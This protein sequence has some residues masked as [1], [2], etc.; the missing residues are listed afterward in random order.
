MNEAVAQ[1]I[2]CQSQY[3]LIRSGVPIKE[4]TERAKITD[5]KNLLGTLGIGLADSIVTTI[6]AFKPQKNL[7]DFLKI[8]LILKNRPNLKFLV[9]GDGAL[10]Q[11]LE[12][13]ILDLG[14]GGNTLLWA[15][16]K[17]SPRY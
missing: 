13:Q 10:R 4:I 15:G 11:N 7:T 2:G 16:G 3:K 14:I 5:K 6:G 17:I 12:K 8:S 1:R 9:I